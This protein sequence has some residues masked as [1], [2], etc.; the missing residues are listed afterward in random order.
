ML[1]LNYKNKNTTISTGNL[2]SC[3]IIISLYISIPEKIW[4]ISFSEVIQNLLT[5][6]QIFHLLLQRQKC[7]KEISHSA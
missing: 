5:Y 2:F 4:H 3:Y 6:G 1:S 7:K